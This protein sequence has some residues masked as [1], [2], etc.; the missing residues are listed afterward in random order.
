MHGSRIGGAKL[1]GPLVEAF[2]LA[3]EFEVKSLD[4]SQN[5]AG[6]LVVFARL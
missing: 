6:K 2:R 5:P 1:S 3:A 4:R